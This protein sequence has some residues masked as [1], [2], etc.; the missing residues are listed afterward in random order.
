MAPRKTIKEKGPG[1]KVSAFSVKKREEGKCKVEFNLDNY[2][3]V[4]FSSLF[5]PKKESRKLQEND[6]KAGS[7]GT[8]QLSTLQDQDCLDKVNRNQ[9]YNLK[10]CI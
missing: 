2:N 7:S 9:F 6:Q 10:T 3:A 8:L 1:S 4:A 5:A